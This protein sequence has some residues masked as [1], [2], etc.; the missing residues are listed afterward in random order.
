MSRKVT[1]IGAGNVGATV[2]YTIAVQGTANEIVIVDVAKEKARGEAMDMRQGSSYMPGVKI[3]NGEY[4]DAVDSDIVVI[5]CGIGR[6]P[7][8]TRLDLA[9]VNADLM[10]NHIIPDITK[11]APDAVYIIVSNP[12]DI[13]TYIMTKYSGIPEERIIGSGTILDSS[14]LRTAIADSYKIDEGSIHASV[15]GEHG[16]SSFAAWSVARI[17]CLSIDEY[18]DRVERYMDGIEAFDKE[19]MMNFVRKSGGMIISDK[20]ATFNAIALCTSYLVKCIF[21]E[22]PT[23]VPVSTMFHGEYGVSDVCLSMECIIGE[24]GVKG[25]LL[26]PLTEE[27]EQLMRKSA[28]SIKA[29]I[30]GLNI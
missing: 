30:N 22:K 28:D 1:I 2:A 24:G 3:Y 13:L 27:E 21:D 23:V 20:G 26:A 4:S 15:Y 7:G 18:K 17:G 19:E 10:R 14:R 6:K 12:V 8:Q 11:Y 29:V 5:T 25:K 16:D 9:K